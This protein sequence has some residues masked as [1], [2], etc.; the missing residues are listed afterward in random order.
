MPMNTTRTGTGVWTELNPKVPRVDYI[1]VD[2]IDSLTGWCVGKN[3][4]IIKT[5]NGGKSWINCISSTTEVLLK[6]S[7]YNGNVVIV[8]G[9]NGM[10]LRSSDNGIN[11]TQVY[12]GGSN[13][14]LWGLQMLNDTLGWCCG[15]SS[16]L[17][18]TTNGGQTWQQVNTGFTGIDYWSLDFLNTQ[19]GMLACGG[20]KILKTTDG[21][22]NWQQ[23]QAGDTR[24]L[25]T[26]D[27]IDSL[28]IVTAGDIGKNVYSSNG[29]TTWIQNTDIGSVNGTN[30]IRF[31]DNDTGYAVSDLTEL[32]KTTN[33]GVNWFSPGY[34]AVGQ[35]DLELLPNGV[36]YAVGEAT[37]IAG[38]KHG[39]DNWDLLIMSDMFRDV[40][41][42]SADTGYA[43]SWRMIKTTNG[44]IIW[45]TVPGATGGQCIKFINSQVGF[46]GSASSYQSTRIYKT[47]NAGTSWYRTNMIGLVDTNTN[48]QKIFFINDRIGW[49]IINYRGAIFKTTDSG[50]NWFVQHT[51]PGDNFTSIYFVDTLNGWATSRYI[52]QTTNGGTNWIQRSDIPI[53]FSNDIYFTHI[54]T[55]FVIKGFTGYN[56]YKTKNGGLSWS[57]D[58]II[59]AGYNFNYFPNRYHWILNGVHNRWETTNNGMTWI[60]ITQYVPSVFNRFQAPKEWIGYAVGG[61]GLILKYLD[62]SYIPVELIS[63][64]GKISN[65]NILIEWI[66]ASETNNKGFE[67]Q[68]SIDRFEWITLGYISGKGTSTETNYYF[69]I[70]TEVK[71]GKYF[72]R[73]KQTD[74]DGSVKFSS[75][76]EINFEFSFEYSLMQ[77]YPNPFNSQTHITFSLP[78]ETVIRIVLFDISG[79]EI[80]TLLNKRLAFGN[81]TIKVNL[82]DLTSGVYF[83]GMETSEGFSSFKKLVLIK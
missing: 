55:G 5:T 77:N 83:F 22:N 57:Q 61:A 66:T 8:S 32:R 14:D 53:S 82:N 28:H 9:Y 64:N 58:S 67:I 45:E 41:F 60:E 47:T 69:Y 51:L 13:I 35:W 48:V 11:F 34:D 37:R 7:S 44:G 30:R 21:G 23:I 26:T 3:G 75:V 12:N 6:V 74:Y 25:Y 16:R 33:R 68:R 39:Y 1:G 27:I 54:D 78:C 43:T 17:L 81:Y 19:Y 20:G 71:T 36:G 40:Y 65:N 2:F 29:G 56:L 24:N 62:T 4:T 73:L 76:I 18:K 59:G 63:F 80:K 50:E 70:D 52:W 42:T 79:S 46:I 10:I 72:Y 49:A 15:R 31:L 38:T